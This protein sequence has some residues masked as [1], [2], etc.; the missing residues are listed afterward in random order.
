MRDVE[1]TPAPRI[2]ESLRPLFNGLAA[3]TQKEVARE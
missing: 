1:L 3:A 2:D